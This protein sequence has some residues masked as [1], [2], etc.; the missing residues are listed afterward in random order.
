MRWISHI[1]P[2]RPISPI[3]KLPWQPYQETSPPGIASCR[4][5]PTIGGTTRMPLTVSGMAL[6]T[7]AEI[8]QEPAASAVPLTTL[9]TT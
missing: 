1:C 2:I 4:A 9:V 6:A 3:P 5:V 8:S 7:G